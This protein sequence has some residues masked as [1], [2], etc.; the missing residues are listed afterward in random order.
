MRVKRPQKCFRLYMRNNNG[1][2]LSWEDWNF[3]SWLLSFTQLS[4]SLCVWRVSWQRCRAQIGGTKCGTTTQ[5]AL[6]ACSVLLCRSL[7]VQVLINEVILTF[8][9]VAGPPGAKVR[10]DKNMC[11]SHKAENNCIFNHTFPLQVILFWSPS[12]SLPFSLPF[13]LYVF[14]FPTFFL[15]LFSLCNQ[16]KASTQR[17][18]LPAS[19]YSILLECHPLMPFRGI[20]L[21]F[22]LSYPFLS[23]SFP[24]LPSLPPS[25][26]R[27]WTVPSVFKR[28]AKDFP[29]SFNLGLSQSGITWTLSRLPNQAS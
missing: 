20:F 5:G 6:L 16:H 15:H 4:T 10:T 26:L 7:P 29:Q 25:L 28:E 22:E 1:V 21:S 17:P 14:L 9:R 13:L 19:I 24:P 2:L 27:P 3:P 12:S 8:K 18:S 11:Q 23:P